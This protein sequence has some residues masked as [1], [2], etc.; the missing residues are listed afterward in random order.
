M[1]CPTKAVASVFDPA[2]THVT[3]ISGP[4][5]SKEAGLN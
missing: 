4:E 5:L 3:S 2:M 1:T